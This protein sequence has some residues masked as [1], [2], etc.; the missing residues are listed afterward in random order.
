MCERL[1]ALPVIQSQRWRSQLPLLQAVGRASAVDNGDMYLPG[2]ENRCGL[3]AG[4]F[5]PVLGCWCARGSRDRVLL[6]E[7]VVGKESGRRGSLPVHFPAQKPILLKR[8]PLRS[9][10]ILTR[11]Y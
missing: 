10:E 3:P 1:H 9:S 5:V 8:E 11:N 4:R 6:Q 2:D 7:G